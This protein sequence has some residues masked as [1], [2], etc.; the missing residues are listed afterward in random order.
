[1]AV[2]GATVGT[3]RATLAPYFPGVDLDAY[4]HSMTVSGLLPLSTA[5]TSRQAALVLIAL[6]T[7]VGPT[8]A[9]EEALR[10]A[11]L[12]LRTSFKDFVTWH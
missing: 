12:E 5:V 7:G 6:S 3:L 4:F 1:M 2:V 8:E 9:P 10:I 11:A